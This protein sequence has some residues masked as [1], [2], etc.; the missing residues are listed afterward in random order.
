MENHE[1]KIESGKV[2]IV[3]IDD[4]TQLVRIDVN[5]KTKQLSYRKF[6][7]VQYHPVED[8]DNVVSEVRE[9][10]LE[11]EVMYAKVLDIIFHYMDR[12]EQSMLDKHGLKD[13]SEIKNPLIRKLLSV[14]YIKEIDVPHR[15]G[16]IKK[17]S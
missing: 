6:G 7:N 3:D 2:Y 13:V 8:I 14:Q 10:S 17:S 1:I 9:E 12:L 15:W 16:D 11:N 4:V 5:P